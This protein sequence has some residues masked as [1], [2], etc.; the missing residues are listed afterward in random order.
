MMMRFLTAAGVLLIA[1]CGAGG[2]TAN[3][4]PAA[5]SAAIPVPEPSGLS[6]VTYLNALTCDPSKSQTTLTYYPGQKDYQ[7]NIVQPGY[8]EVFQLVYNL[9]QCNN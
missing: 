9:A 7:G 2:T 5:S 4:V 8:E 1:G 6:T 3:P